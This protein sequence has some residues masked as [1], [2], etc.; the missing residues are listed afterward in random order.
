M[1]KLSLIWPLGIP[2]NWHLGPS[3]CWLLFSLLSPFLHFLTFWHNMIVQ[4]L[5]VLPYLTYGT[6]HFSKSLC[7]LSLGNGI[8]NQDLGPECAHCYWGVIDSWPFQS[9]KLRNIQRYMSIHNIHAHTHTQ[10]WVHTNASNST[11]FAQGSFLTSLFHIF[12]FLI[13]QWQH[14]LPTTWTNLLITQS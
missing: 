7:F 13:P 1:L 12:T 10:I 6:T 11:L 9:T 8:R 4:F 5:I 14:L 2:S 3:S